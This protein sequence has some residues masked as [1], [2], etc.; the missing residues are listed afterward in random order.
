MKLGNLKN[1][2]MASWL[3]EQGFRLDA[4]PFLSGA[5]EARKLLEQLSVKKEP[6]ASLTKGHNGGIFN[7]P[8]FAR[9]YVDDPEHGVPFVGSSDM[10][11]ADLSRLPLLRKKEAYSP[12]LAYLRLEKG[13]TLI[14]CSGTIGRM[15]YV[16]PDMA[17]M[18]S[19]QHIRRF[20][21]KVL[22]ASPH[23][24]SYLPP[25]AGG[26]DLP[27]AG[28]GQV[29][30]GPAGGGAWGRTPATCSPLQPPPAG[31][32]QGVHPHCRRPQRG[33]FFL[34]NRLMSGERMHP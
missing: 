13:M 26:C 32:R 19:S 27:P 2:V 15:V 29:G 33:R 20:P 23:L 34:R 12:A 21:G 7:G 11:Q 10:L 8:K 22:H 16:R 9:T 5:I 3:R 14:S 25:R 4:P 30:G 17:G 28:G 18:W 31:G 6:L 1:P 24:L